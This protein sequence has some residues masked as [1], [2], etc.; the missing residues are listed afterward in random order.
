MLCM[1]KAFTL[2]RDEQSCVCLCDALAW[3]HIR[4]L[5][6]HAM[7]IFGRLLWQVLRRPVLFHGTFDFVLFCIS[8][9]NGDIGWV[10]PKTGTRLVLVL[11][12]A[13]G[14]PFAILG[15]ARHNIR[16]HNIRISFDL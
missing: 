15:A 4:R 7:L 16:K 2:R 10:H 6:H 12:L 14:M 3:W 8:T 11:K 13:L 1:S 9:T 5:C